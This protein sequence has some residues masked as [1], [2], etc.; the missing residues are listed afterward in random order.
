MSWDRWG[1]TVAITLS[2]ASVALLAVTLF[3]Q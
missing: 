1:L 3:L 2:L